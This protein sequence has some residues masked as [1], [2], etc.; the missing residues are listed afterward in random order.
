MAIDIGADAIARALTVNNSTFRLCLIEGSNPATKSG[1]IKKVYFYLQ[2]D[3]AFAV[4]IGIFYKTNGDTF[5]SRDSVTIP[6]AV[7]GL[8]E[9]DVELDIQVGDYIGILLV[10]MPGGNGLALAYDAEWTN[11]Y[12]RTLAGSTFPYTDYEFN[13]LGKRIISVYGEL[14]KAGMVGMNPALKEL[15]GY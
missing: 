8:N 3:I 14:E 6:E 11:D 15:M 7:I 5:S 1:T 13:N 4:E 9:A 2:G 12:W 10:Q